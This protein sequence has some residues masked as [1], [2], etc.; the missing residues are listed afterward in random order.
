MPALTALTNPLPATTVATAVLL[1][2]HTPPALPLELYCAVA[3]IHSGVLP[4]TVPDVR[5]GFTVKPWP[6]DE[7]PQLLLTV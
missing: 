3:L 7:L 1:L 4:L 2:L 5:T 6:D